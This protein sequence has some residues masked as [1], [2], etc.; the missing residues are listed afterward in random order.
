MYLWVRWWYDDLNQQVPQE[1]LGDAKDC[2]PLS[3]AFSK[4]LIL[5]VS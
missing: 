4:N 2:Q 1:I 5:L 3:S